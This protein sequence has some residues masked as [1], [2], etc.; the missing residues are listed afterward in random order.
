MEESLYLKL[1]SNQTQFIQLDSWENM[2][3]IP[4]DGGNVNYTKK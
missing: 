4:A 2:G 3:S 1:Y